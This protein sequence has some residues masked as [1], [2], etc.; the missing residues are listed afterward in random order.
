M[1][2]KMPF[3]DTFIRYGTLE[4]PAQGSSGVTYVAN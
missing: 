3:C 2:G 4:A 1:A